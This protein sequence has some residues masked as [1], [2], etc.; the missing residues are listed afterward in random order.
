MKLIV[1]LRR[2]YGAFVDRNTGLFIPPGKAE[3]NIEVKDPESKDLSYIAKCVESG[4][5]VCVEGFELLGVKPPKG[6]GP[7]QETIEVEEE[8]VEEKPAEETME[9]APTD[10][11]QSLESKSYRE[12][13]QI[14]KDMDLKAS[15]STEELIERIKD[16][17]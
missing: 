1:R 17:M 6:D 5:L 2:K 13:Q 7:S 8:T 16:N 9:E 4:K 15:G 3:K 10:E 14:A 12:L 11:E